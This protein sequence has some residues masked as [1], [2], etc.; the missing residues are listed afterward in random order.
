MSTNIQN[1]PKSRYAGLLD[2]ANIILV[3]ALVLSLSF[4]VSYARANLF[5]SRDNARLKESVTKLS[6]IE[7]GDIVPA[8]EATDLQGKPNNVS[9]SGSKRHLLLVFSTNCSACAGQFPLWARI[10]LQARAKDWLVQAVSLDSADDTRAYFEDKGPG[11]DVVVPKKSIL[12][13]YR[14]SVIPQVLLITAE[15]TVDWI[16]RGSLSEAQVQELLARI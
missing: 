16:N 6:T 5:L 3:I 10:A 14:V 4:L 2:P 12:R 9:Y 7:V 1:K 11:F 15:G 8:F 13:M